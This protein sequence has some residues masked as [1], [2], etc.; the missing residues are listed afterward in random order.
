MPGLAAGAAQGLQLWP[1]SGRFGEGHHGDAGDNSMSTLGRPFRWFVST[2]LAG[3]LRFR[4]ILLV[5]LASLPSLALLLL[6]AAQQRDEALA[7]GQ[8]EAQRL[9][10]LVAADQA[11]VSGQVEL[12]LSTLALLPELGGSTPSSCSATLQDLTSNSGEPITAG[13]GRDL[14]V[15]GA[16]YQNVV[17]LENDLTLF[18]VGPA[19]SDEISSADRALALSALEHGTLVKGNEQTAANGSL[20]VT[21]AVPFTTDAG[22]RVIVATMEIYALTTF[23]REANL[24]DGSII[25]I[26]DGNGV[27]EQRYPAQ[28]GIGA[29]Q[30]LA[31]T[32]V[33]DETIDRDANDPEEETAGDVDV[34][35]ETYVFASDDFWTPGPRG[36]VDLSYTMVGLPRAAIVE[37]ANE[38][39][40]ENLGKLG[41]AGIIALIA[42]WIGADLFVGR[43]AETRK[44]HIRDL[45]HAFSTG[46]IN[47][48]DQVI[49]PGYVDRSAGPSQAPGIDGLRQNIAVFRTAFPDGKITIRELLSDHD[50]VVARVTLSGTHVADYFG[51][52]PS[53]KPVTADG[54]EIFRF[55]HGMVV[56]S[57]S[58][59]GAMRLRARV[60]EDV[61][62][63]PPAR[64]RR[65]RLFGRRNQPAPA[66]G[67][68]R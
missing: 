38:K 65:W 18:C 26:V 25:V 11:N 57:W 37:R 53:G 34:D 19:G 68:K 58:L 48:L 60:A 62:P 2:R 43:D 29:G 64:S 50:K 35:G 63:P 40:N 52:A 67:G 39:F 49:G 20:V 45:Y 21:Y 3:S 55:M 51:I 23:V 6:T 30:S 33:V 14:R 5:L 9:A 13:A 10:R 42:A 56:E 16:S 24:P 46:S 22:R 66:Q 7:A 1:R 12:V 47:N 36:N 31:G 4:L 44:G 61:A 27:L 32:P 8:Q 59:F 41:I 54:M 17:V 15:A 28:A